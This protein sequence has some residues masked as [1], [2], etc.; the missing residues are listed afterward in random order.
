MARTSPSERELPPPL[1]PERRTVGQLVAE[2]IRLYGANFFRAL[3]LGVIVAVVD[4]FRLGTRREVSAAVFVLAAPIF[5]LAYAIAV[6]LA[7]GTTAPVKR[8]LVALASGTLVFLPAAL[9]FPW[10]ALAS[11]LW[12]ALAGLTVPAA[13]VEG[14]SVAGSVRRGVQLAR[15]GYV[16]AAGSIAALVVLFALAQYGL[17]LL[18]S[19]QAD[20]TVRTAVFLADVVVGP[21]LF[22]GAGLLYFDQEARLRS[23]GNRGEERDGDVSDVDDVDGEGRADASRESRPVA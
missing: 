12:L 3:P 5:T 13:M 14:T 17:A 11:V 19:S 6:K 22:L 20:N 2:S 8:W 10:F 4:Q 23:R 7:T 16:H 1:P 18:L 21:L 15:A 9:A